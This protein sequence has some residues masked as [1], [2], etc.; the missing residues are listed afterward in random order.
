LDVNY[1][2][3]A[4]DIHHASL[5]HLVNGLLL[6]NPV[7]RPTTHQLMD[8]VIIKAHIMIQQVQSL[9]LGLGKID[10]CPCVRDKRFNLFQVE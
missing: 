4:L 2:R 5:R 3:K 9:S 8:T 1:D 7:Q 10:D 6:K